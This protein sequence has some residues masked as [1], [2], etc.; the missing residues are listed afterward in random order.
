MKR[1]CKEVTVDGTMNALGFNLMCLWFRLRDLLSPPESILVEVG[2]RPGFQVLDYG[3]GPGSHSIV[4]AELVGRSGKVYA[5]DINSLALQ[6]VQK[7]ASRKGLRNIE[8]IHTDCATGLQNDRLD[9]VL[10]YDTY[11]DLDDPGSVLEELHRILKPH[12]VL[13]FSDH[14]MS[15]DE[16]LTQV[17]GDGFFQLS[18]KGRK[19]YS[20]LKEG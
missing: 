6:R 18:S 2:I 4:A 20:F 19:T 1:F 5:A 16:I 11:H 17:T 15:E 9:V 12:S 13:S 3:C 8:T 10:L 14:H 7:V